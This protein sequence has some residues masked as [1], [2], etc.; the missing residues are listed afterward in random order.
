[1]TGDLLLALDQG[2]TSTRTIAF[3]AALTPLGREIRKALD[4]ALSSAAWKLRSAV[5]PS[6][7]CKV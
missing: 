1:M 7:V 4:D 6:S 2:T 5:R 3:D